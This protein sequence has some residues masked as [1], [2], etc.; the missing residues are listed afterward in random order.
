ML[1]RWI[2][3]EERL[4]SL[5]QRNAVGEDIIEES[6]ILYEELKE[7]SVD[8][9]IE[10][11]VDIDLD[12]LSAKAALIQNTLLVGRLSLPTEMPLRLTEIVN[13]IA[14]RVV[15]PGVKRDFQHALG[16]YC[17]DAAEAQRVMGEL[18]LEEDRLGSLLRTLRAFEDLLN[19]WR[20]TAK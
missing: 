5:R 20:S 14:L 13:D 7:F 6:H 16:E 4:K 12:I 2:E 3:F 9:S 1:S 8:S 11:L 17:A 10:E 19:S 15:G 18:R